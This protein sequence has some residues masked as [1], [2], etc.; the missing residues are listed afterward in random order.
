MKKWRIWILAA[1][2]VLCGCGGE[3]APVFETLGGDALVPGEKPVAGII[4]LNIPENAVSEAMSDPA[5]GELYTW[6]GNTLQLQ[7]LDAGDIR[8]T[9]ETL[10][11]MEYED[12]T[13]MSWKKENMTYYRTV[14]STAGEEGVLLGQALIADDGF[15]HYCVSLLSPETS[16]AR[17]LYE[18]LLASFAVMSVDEVK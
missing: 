1:A 9:V 13:V 10:T 14:W 3:E 8:L 15:Y 12:L 16:D 2:M 7:T 4:H 5:G 18:R 6:D 11:G 17:G